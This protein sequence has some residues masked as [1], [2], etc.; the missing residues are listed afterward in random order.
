M[1]EAAELLEG[2]MGRG[3]RIGC[4]CVK[5]SGQEF[6]CM[7]NTLALELNESAQKGTGSSHKKLPDLLFLCVKSCNSQTFVPGH[8]TQ[9]LSFKL[10]KKKK[11]IRFCHLICSLLTPTLIPHCV[12][13]EITKGPRK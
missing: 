9:E 8:H 6:L 4:T 12:R 3:K 1:F 11:K 2:D 5:K 10:Q 13:I 7:P